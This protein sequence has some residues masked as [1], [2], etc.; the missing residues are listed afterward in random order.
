MLTVDLPKK[1]E[2]LLSE[3]ALKT[4]HSE[5]YYVRKAVEHFLEDQK[6]YIVALQRL[7]EMEAENDEGVP[8]E[9]ILRKHK[10]DD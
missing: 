10:L 5:S 1:L 7:E 3:L 6:D 4:Q 8:F 9:D 2:A